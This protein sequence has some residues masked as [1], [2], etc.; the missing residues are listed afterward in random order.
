[1]AK[2]TGI[3]IAILIV[4]GII[5]SIVTSAIEWNKKRKL[6]KMEEE[7]TKAKYKEL[8]EKEKQEKKEK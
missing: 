1:M 6:D 3:I 8:I 2:E 7:L 5:A 4:V